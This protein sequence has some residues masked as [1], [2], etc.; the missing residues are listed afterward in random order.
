MGREHRSGRRANDQ[1]KYCTTE[2]GTSQGKGRRIQNYH[3][4][5]AAWPATKGAGFHAAI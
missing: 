2:C 5:S 4:K 3:R 1:R